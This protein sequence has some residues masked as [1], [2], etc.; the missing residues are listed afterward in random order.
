MKSIEALFPAPRRDTAADS[1]AEY[2]KRRVSFNDEKH[3]PRRDRHATVSELLPSQWDGV[4][5]EHSRKTLVAAILSGVDQLLESPATGPEEPRRTYDPHP[6]AGYKRVLETVLDTLLSAACCG[7]ERNDFTALLLPPQSAPTAPHIFGRNEISAT[8]ECLNEP[9]TEGRDD[10]LAD[11]PFVND[12][13]AVAV[14]AP[15]YHNLVQFQHASRPDLSATMA[16]Q[17][18]LRRSDSLVSGQSSVAAYGR[19][20]STVHAVLNDGFADGTVELNEYILIESIGHGVQGEVFIAMDTERNELRAVKAVPRPKGAF[21]ST[22]RAQGNSIAAARLRKRQQLEREVAVMKQCRHANVVRLYEVIDDPQQDK[23]YLVMQYVE[24]GSIAHLDKSGVPSRTIEPG[25]LAGYARQVVRGLEYLHR[26]GV[27]HR[28]IKPDNILL[29]Q[30][31]KVYLADFGLAE[32]FD[33]NMNTSGVAGT[34]GTVAFLAPELF[35]DEATGAEG[36]TVCGRA[37]DVWALGVTLYILLYGKSPFMATAKGNFIDAVLTADIDFPTLGA[38]SVPLQLGPG[39]S[40][41]SLDQEYRSIGPEASV[42][43]SVRRGSEIESS[44][45]N[46]T[47]EPCPNTPHS[48]RSDLSADAHTPR[49]DL[50]RPSDAP[51][52]A[53]EPSTPRQ[54]ETIDSLWRSLLRG[55]LHR[56]PNARLT[57]RAVRRCLAEIESRHFKHEQHHPRPLG[58]DQVRQQTSIAPFGSSITQM[59]TIRR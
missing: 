26:K 13:F 18:E 9:E 17:P 56:S 36:A 55:M 6:V 2:S 15:S 57:L 52:A 47:L 16:P 8:P 4:Q 42:V 30:D 25:T 10:A 12:S 48:A 28:D 46:A 14:T 39:D 32:M 23:M 49:F 29:G 1:H 19:V 11:V 35:S 22:H 59:H 54:A 45:L 5:D 24:H 3:V 31:D 38:Y 50:R 7:T 41:R 43:S 20:H 33:A 51:A 58:L 40:S 53:G 44:H 21:D 34:C 27:I 37:V